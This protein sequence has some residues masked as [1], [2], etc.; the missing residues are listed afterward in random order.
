MTNILQEL[1]QRIESLPL[2]S[3]TNPVVSCARKRLSEVIGCEP[4]DIEIRG[5]VANY[6]FVLFA[7]DVRA[8]EGEAYSM[9]IYTDSSIV[10][11]AA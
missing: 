11:V 7:R 1:T 2:L 8:G 5:E 3:V 6:G 4:H 9:H 10:E